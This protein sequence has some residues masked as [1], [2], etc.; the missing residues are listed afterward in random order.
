MTNRELEAFLGH[1][2]EVHDAEDPGC[3]TIEAQVTIRGRTVTLGFTGPQTNPVVRDIVVSLR[4]T[5]WT[6][7]K[8]VAALKRQVP[9]VVYEPSRHQPEATEKENSGPTYVLRHNRDVAI[10]IKPGEAL[11][12]SPNDCLD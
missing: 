10:L 4:G 3:S 11:F 9:D 12:I 6:K 1:K 2:V 8:L 7:D 5:T